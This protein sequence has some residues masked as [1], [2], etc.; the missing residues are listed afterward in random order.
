M[1]SNQLSRIRASA[2][3][4]RRQET[5]MNAQAVGTTTTRRDTAMSSSTRVAAATTTTL[6]PRRSA[7]MLAMLWPIPAHCHPL[8]VTAMTSQPV[9][10]SIDP[11]ADVANSSSPDVAAIV[12]TLS[13]SDSVWII[14]EGRSRH[15]NNQS[16]LKNLRNPKN[17][18]SL[19]N[20]KNLWR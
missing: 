4:Q 1:R 7:R 15:H 19:N 13:R 14:V 5:V 20:L 17:L 9:G 18:K 8:R 12:I 10:T 2:T 3:G 6:D 16:N 11:R